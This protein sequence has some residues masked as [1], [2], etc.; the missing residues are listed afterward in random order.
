[1]SSRQTFKNSPDA[2]LK[3]LRLTPGASPSLPALKN[4]STSVTQEKDASSPSPLPTISKENLQ[5]YEKTGKEVGLNWERSGKEVGNLYIESGGKGEFGSEEVEQIASEADTSEITFNKPDSIQAKLS[6][7]E[8]G[9]KSEKT[10]KEVGNFYIKSGKVEE[11][12]PHKV[13]KNW[14][15]TGKQVGNK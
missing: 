1:M 6:R 12:A 15:E 10:G 7:K 8:V 3:K 11:T 2:F 4:E 9:N 14:E 5:K 13:G